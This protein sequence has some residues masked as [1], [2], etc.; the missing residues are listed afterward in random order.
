PIPQTDYYRVRAVFEPAYDVGSWRS[1]TARRISL[2]SPADRAKA[3][4][5]EQEAVKVD[6]E[7]Q[8]KQAEYIEAT[9]QKQLANLSQ[10]DRPQVEKA[11]RTPMAKRS[12]AQKKL[13]QQHPSVNVSAG[14]LY[15]YDK[16]AADDLAKLTEQATKLRAT[17]PVED[18]ID[19][20]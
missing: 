12:A 5:V 11:Y 7:R 4:K 18:Y 8:K 9:L 14:S 3:Q 19:A 13:L 16:K 2:L 1:A 6:A 20:L 15:L 17:K 10:A